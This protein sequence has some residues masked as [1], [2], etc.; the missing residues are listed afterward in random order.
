MTP[1]A[2]RAITRG[3]DYLAEHQRGDGSFQGSRGANTGIVSFAVLSF[4]ATGEMPDRGP[5]GELIA[6]SIGFVL[7]QVLPSGLISNPQDSSNGPMYEHAMSVLMLAEVSGDYEHPKLSR[8]LH[9]GVELIVRSQNATGGWR[10]L[11][12]SR[13]AD[14]SVTVMQVVALRAARDAGITV[15]RRTMD[16]A[17][18]YVK[19]CATPSGGFLY[20]PGRG[21]PGYARTGAG[22]C[23]LLLGGQWAAPE[24]HRG[25][26]YLQEHKGQR[27]PIDPYYGLYYA[28]HAMYLAPNPGEWQAWFPPIREELLAAQAPDGRWDGEAGPLY[29]TQMAILTLAVPLRQLPVYQR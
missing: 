20:Q 1:A 4:L 27:G 18:A 3:L 12:G 19:R 6:R 9:R 21:E 5:R 10:Y 22:V 25:V 24:T 2:R 28:S 11:P 17:L 13:D 16:A 26:G 23:A 15:P 7:E 8:T 14:L 29:G